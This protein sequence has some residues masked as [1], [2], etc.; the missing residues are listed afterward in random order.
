MRVKIEVECDNAAFQDGQ[1]YNELRR[2]LRQALRKVPKLRR[3]KP[4]LCDA[5]EADDVLLD[6]NGNTVGRVEVFA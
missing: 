2:I 5:P 1:L 4:C 6:T 3:R